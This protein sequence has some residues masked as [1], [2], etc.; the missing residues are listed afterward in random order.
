[1]KRILV[2]ILFVIALSVGSVGCSEK[3]KVQETKTTQGP[4]GTTKETKTEEVT[5]SGENP[6]PATKEP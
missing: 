2:S 1:M 4:G 5:K 6:P 3:A